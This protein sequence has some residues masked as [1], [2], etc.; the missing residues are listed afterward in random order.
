MDPL[1]Q[2]QTKT[3]AVIALG[4]KLLQ[5]HINESSPFT[6]LTKLADDSL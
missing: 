2:A 6:V 4:T 5:N 3:Y 1:V